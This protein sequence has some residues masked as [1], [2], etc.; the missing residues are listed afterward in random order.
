[1]KALLYKDFI[2]LLRQFKSFFFIVALFAFV[3]LGSMSAFFVIYAGILPIISLISLDQRAKW[4][5]LAAML[6]YT[7]RE[8]VFSRY[9]MGWIMT[10]FA[11]VVYLL[12][13]QFLNPGIGPIDLLTILT[14]I[15]G[16]LF[17]QAVFFPIIFRFG[18]EQGRIIGILVCVLV[19]LAIGGSMA[20]LTPES[21]LTSVAML[22][23]IFLVVGLVLCLASVKVSEKMYLKRK[24]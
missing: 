7:T 23:S 22:P 19:G 17:M 4:D 24:W 20:V 6:P 5:S 10:A 3:N 9:V 16:I 8:L 12:G 1:M 18:V 21:I 14:L 11:C 15:A 2:V 13:R